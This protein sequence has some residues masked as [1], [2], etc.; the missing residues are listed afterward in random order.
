LGF[1]L[2]AAIT[3]IAIVVSTLRKI[4]IVADLTQDGQVTRGFVFIIITVGITIT[5]ISVSKTFPRGE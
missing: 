1:V 2:I 3:G 4:I 5:I